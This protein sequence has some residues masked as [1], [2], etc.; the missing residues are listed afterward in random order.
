MM[1]LQAE[2]YIR[3]HADEF[4]KTPS[5]IIKQACIELHPKYCDAVE[6]IASEELNRLLMEERQQFENEY[7][8]YC[9][10]P[11]SYH[12]PAGM[13]MLRFFFETHQELFL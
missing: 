2:D 12:L 4:K 8:N 10:H 6:M 9:Q 7:Q 1:F 13:D 3:N 5:D 11:D